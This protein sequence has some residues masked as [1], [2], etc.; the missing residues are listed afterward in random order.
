MKIVTLAE[1]TAL[2]PELVSEHGLSL[3]VETPKHKLLFDVGASPAFVANARKLNVDLTAVDL[4]IISHGHNDHGGGLKAFMEINPAAKIYVHPKAFIKHYASRPD[5]KVVEIGLDEEL[6]KDERIVLTGDR[7][8]IDEELELIGN[9]QGDLFIPSGNRVLLMARNGQLVEDDF[10]HEQNLII[11]TAAKTYLIAG[12]AHR[13]IIN[14]INHIKPLLDR[15]IDCIIGGYHLYNKAADS[16]EDPEI[17]RQ[18]AEYL[19]ELGATC[20]TCHC[21]GLEPYKQL[22]AVLGEKMQYLATGS[23]LVI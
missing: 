13:G 6:Q 19:R 12:C 9:V 7:F 21:T 1:N 17:V 2:S 15:P 11:K 22:R 3:Y 20:Y 8:V 18:I 4:A 23:V 16:N 14:I 5:G 10:A